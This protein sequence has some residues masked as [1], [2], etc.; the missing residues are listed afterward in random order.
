MQAHAGGSYAGGP[1]LDGASARDARVP[2][3]SPADTRVVVG[4]TRDAT[5][6]EIAR[7]LS[8]RRRRPAG[9][10]CAAGC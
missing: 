8:S 5:A 4:F 3:V 6:A 9:L 7:A 10:G 1:I 2:V